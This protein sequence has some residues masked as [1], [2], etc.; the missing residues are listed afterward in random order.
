MQLPG[1][2]CSKQKEAAVYG[3]KRVL[4]DRSG[5]WVR[6]FQIL[7]IKGL[8]LQEKADTFSLWINWIREVMIEAQASSVISAAETGCVQS[9]GIRRYR[10][11]VVW[12]TG[13]NERG[14]C[15]RI[16]F[17]ARRE[18]L[19]W[20]R[21]CGRLSLLWSAIEGMDPVKN[22]CHECVP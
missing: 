20:R 3:N 5:Q 17:S 12:Q 4:T 11:W 19:G 21:I 16:F 18:V 2:P 15:R 8:H 7:W 22:K 13:W 9:M 10:L 14:D 1:F 6:Y